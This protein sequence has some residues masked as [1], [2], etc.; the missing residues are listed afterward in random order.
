MR[1]RILLLT[2]LAF[3]FL[4][5]APRAQAIDIHLRVGV[6]VNLPPYQFVNGDEG[7]AGLVKEL[8]KDHT[9]G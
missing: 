6:N 8:V 9:I 4:L 3:L 7:I 1:R 5:P 2:L